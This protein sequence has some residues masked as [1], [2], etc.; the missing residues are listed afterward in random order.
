M[1]CV[2]G[3]GFLFADSSSLH[4]SIHSDTHTRGLS[5]SASLSLFL[6]HLNGLFKRLLSVSTRSLVRFICAESI[7]RGRSR[8]AVCWAEELPCGGSLR[9]KRRLSLPK[10]N[11][12]S[13]VHRWKLERR[14][15]VSYNYNSSCGATNTHQNN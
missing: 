8:G 9:G 12:L 14:V 10:V 13:V 7:P 4:L 15:Q 3:R 1:A 5:T 6:V 11:W 2:W